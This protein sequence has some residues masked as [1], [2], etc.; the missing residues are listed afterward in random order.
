MLNYIWT[1][2]GHCRA[3]EIVGEANRGFRRTDYD[4]VCNGCHPML[5]FHGRSRYCFLNVNLQIIFCLFLYSQIQNFQD[6]KGK[7]GILNCHAEIASRLELKVHE[8]SNSASEH[9]QSLRELVPV[10]HLE[11]PL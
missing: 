4:C 5:A 11:T 1:C 8:A 10:A 2:F 9:G 3:I 7:A 6:N